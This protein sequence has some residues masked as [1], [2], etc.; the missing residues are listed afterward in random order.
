MLAYLRE[1][2]VSLKTSWSNMNMEALLRLLRTACR[3]HLQVYIF[4]YFKKAKITKRNREDNVPSI[5][6]AST[7]LPPHHFPAQISAGFG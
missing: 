4:E 3:L 5:K 2:K 6:E 7:N 1:V